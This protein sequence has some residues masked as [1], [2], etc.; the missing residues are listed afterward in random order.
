MKMI[1]GLG[2]PG[3]GYKATRHNMGFMVIKALADQLGVVLDEKKF[4]ARYGLVNIDCQKVLLVQPYNYMNNSGEVVETLRRYYDVSLQ[5]ILVIV[6]DV[7][8][9]CGKIRLRSRGNSGGHNGLKN[10]IKLLGSNE[11]KRVRIGI[12]KDP[13]VL[14]MDYVLGKPTKQQK[15]LL[16]PALARAK[17]AALAFVSQDFN[18]VMNEYNKTE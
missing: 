8:L 1:V 4:K 3:A 13:L 16:E 12:D 2:N 17:D 15:V 14:G 10:L 11:F 9:P 18:L 6:D 7:D 5:D